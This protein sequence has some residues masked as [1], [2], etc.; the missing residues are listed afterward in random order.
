M[1]EE[2][3]K[4]LSRRRFVALTGGAVVASGIL[5]ACGDNTA[6]TA[7]AATTAAAT[8][9][10]AA[11]TAAPAA[12]TAAATTAA[13]ATTSAGATTAASG[14]PAAFNSGFTVTSDNITLSIW[15][16]DA[17]MAPWYQ[18]VTADYTKLHPNVK[19]D[20]QAFA[21]RDFE[22][23]IAA[24]IP[25]DSAADILQGSPTTLRKYIEPGLIPKTPDSVAKTVA[26]TKIFP[27]ELTGNM[28]FN[29]AYYG[30]PFYQGRH[31]IYYNTDYFTAAGLTTPPATMDDLTTYAQKLVKV[32]GGN[33]TVSG[34]SLRL[35]GAGSG[36]A[37]KFMMFLY[38]N[39][40]NILEKTADGKYHNA[41]N[42]DAGLKTLK[43]FIDMVY[44]YKTDDPKVKHDSDAF[45]TGAT[46]MFARESYVIGEAAKK[47]PN[48]KY[49]T[50]PM[51]KG[52]RW[53]DL[54]S[55]IN[56]FTSRST[57][58]AD[59]AW[60]FIL[61]SQQEMY[62]NLLLTEVG[63]IPQ[64][65]DYTYS[66][67]MKAHPQFAAFTFKDPNYK[68]F[69]TPAIAPFDELE[70]KLADRLSKAFLDSSLLDNEAKMKQMLAD[71]A[72]ETDDILK[73]ANL[74]GA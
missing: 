47:A 16:D 39:G 15:A 62:L 59:T 4:R 49:N 74:Y 42:N 46:A 14:S 10:A 12:T 72:K 32:E 19:F 35:T 28:Q 24:S 13:G 52:V 30:Y 43:M 53:G 1:S 55:P 6:T 60:D 34:L 5:A 25:S 23:K 73:K 41:Y 61:F 63:W 8:T 17:G 18:K 29:N 2:P 26:D 69:V 36:I 7:P 66:E 37:E 21:V 40:G 11:T 71:A 31:A 64:R 54:S 68:L 50:T 38:P 58:N 67:A 51:P 33:M 65:Q 45:E 9:S 44:K 70:T 48:L 3:R 22:T 20:I 57:K 56:L 27:A